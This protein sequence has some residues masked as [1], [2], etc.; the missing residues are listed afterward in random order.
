MKRLFFPQPKGNLLFCVISGV[1]EENSLSS[2][3]KMGVEGV[4]FKDIQVA[5]ICPIVL[6]L[7]LLNLW[8]VKRVT[9]LPNLADRPMEDKNVMTQFFK[10][11]FTADFLGYPSVTCPQIL[12]TGNRIEW[13]IWKGFKH[14]VLNDGS[15]GRSRKDYEGP[16]FSGAKV[17][18]VSSGSFRKVQTLGPIESFC[19]MG[20]Y[21]Q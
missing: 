7:P 19:L 21:I 5:L 1:S 12:R 8:S 13:A 3:C 20:V 4:I 14:K 18:P 10:P 16:C 9:D 15:H 11:F 17:F 2:S 6:Y